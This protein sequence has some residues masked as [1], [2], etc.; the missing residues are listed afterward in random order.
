MGQELVWEN[1]TLETHVLGR[2]HTSGSLGLAAKLRKRPR[3]AAPG[4]GGRAQHSGGELR[5]ARPRADEPPWSL[6]LAGTCRVDSAAPV[7]AHQPDSGAACSLGPLPAA[8]LPGGSFPCTPN[9]KTA[10][11]TELSSGQGPNVSPRI[12][13]QPAGGMGRGAGTLLLL[14]G[15]SRSLVAF[16][17]HMV[18][19]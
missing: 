12:L 2:T 14:P 7:G 1:S 19:R 10:N 17:S 16:V 13:R 5:P 8:H 6:A 9:T 18:C 3:G 4:P 15:C 11:D